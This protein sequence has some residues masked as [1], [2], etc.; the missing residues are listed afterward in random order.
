MHFL[1]LPPIHSFRAQARGP[2]LYRGTVPSVL[3]LSCAER[4]STLRP[5]LDALAKIDHQSQLIQ[6]PTA[7]I[8]LHL[9]HTFSL[10]SPHDSGSFEINLIQIWKRLLVGRNRSRMRN[11]FRSLLTDC[12]HAPE[13]VGSLG[14]TGAKPALNRTPSCD[15]PP[16]NPPQNQMR[17]SSLLYLIHATPSPLTLEFFLQHSGIE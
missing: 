10:N 12:R 8:V 1:A 9:Y 16:L 3:Q 7:T 4:E 14:P 5:D 15:A 2:V 6:S 11:R 17:L 13:L